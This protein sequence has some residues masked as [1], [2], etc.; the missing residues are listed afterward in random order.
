MQIVIQ[1][2]NALS[3]TD[4]FKIGFTSNKY[5]IQEKVRTGCKKKDGFKK[6]I[7]NNWQYTAIHRSETMLLQ[8]FCQKVQSKFP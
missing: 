3:I 4:Y 6:E 7:N 1:T 8:N 2:I 5:Q